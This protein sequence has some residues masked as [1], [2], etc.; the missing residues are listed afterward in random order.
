MAVRCG[1]PTTFRRPR[2]DVI[3]PA[4]GASGVARST[5]VVVVFNEPIKPDTVNGFNFTLTAGATT[6]D[7]SFTLN[8]TNG[9]TFTPAQP[10]AYNT[11]YTVLIRAD[12]IR[13]AAGNGLTSDFGSSFAT[14]TFPAPT[15]TSVTPNSGV[16]G[17]SFQV[18]FTGTQPGDRQC[19]DLDKSGHQ[20]QYRQRCR[21]HRGSQPYH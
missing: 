17:S 10:L 9:F 11:T 12:G 20:R 21:R 16:Q 3:T 19:G 1:L 8:G 14:E 18:T 4:N 6:I 7:G 13:D 2:S 15:L 5:A